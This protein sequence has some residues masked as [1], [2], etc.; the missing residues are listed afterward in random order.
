MK[1]ILS[2]ISCPGHILR[3]LDGNNV[4]CSGWTQFLGLDL[5]CFANCGMYKIITYRVSQKKIFFKLIA[6]PNQLTFFVLLP[7]RFVFHDQSLPGRN[8]HPVLRNKKTRNGTNATG[9]GAFPEQ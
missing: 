4:L 7:D 6:V 3:R 9:K 1:P 5:F 8:S 2:F